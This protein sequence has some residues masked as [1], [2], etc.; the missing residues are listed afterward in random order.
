MCI[1]TT[2]AGV[3]PS[4]KDARESPSFLPENSH[5]LLPTIC[6]TQTPFG[7]LLPTLS[8]AGRPG[9]HLCL[10]HST[11]ISLHTELACP[12]QDASPALGHC[13]PTEPSSPQ[14]H[15]RVLSIPRHLTSRHP[16]MLITGALRPLKLKPMVAINRS[17]VLYSLLWTWGPYTLS[18]CQEIQSKDRENPRTPQS[19]RSLL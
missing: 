13:A 14:A 16:L 1:E 11:H 19:Q 10:L 15:L 4:V 9:N 6:L 18:T 5:G 12:S 17:L 3:N 8:R 2:T 7:S